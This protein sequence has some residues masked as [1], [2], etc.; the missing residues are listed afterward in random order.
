MRKRSLGMSLMEILVAIF[1]MGIV[2][3][4]AYEI[5][6]EGIQ[7]FK[8]NQRASDAQ[9]HCLNLLSQVC[10]QVTNAKEE[11]VKNYDAPG[12]VPGVC[13]ASP[14]ADDG[15][16]HYDL[17]NGNQVFWQKIVFYYLDTT[18]GKVYRKIEKIP[19]TVAGETGNSD[20]GQVEALLA[21]SNTNYFQSLNTNA[22]TLIAE[23][24][25]AFKVSAY[26]P[27]TSGVVPGSGPS[28]GA[29][30]GRAFDIVVE[31]GNPTD[32]GPNGYYLKLD[33]RVAPRG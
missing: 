28:A 7:Y 18:S 24:I 1:V 20:M 3:W 6:R 5:F 21:T 23:D 9:R 16:V 30:G 11:L 15:K 33:S 13:F 31:A 26:N 4:G 14:L 25:V 19:D 12:V 27:A 17:T 22:V 2:V 8:T 10:L 29:G 32:M